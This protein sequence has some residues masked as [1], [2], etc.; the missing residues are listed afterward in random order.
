MCSKAIHES[1]IHHYYTLLHILLIDWNGYSKE[2]QYSY[3]QTNLLFLQDHSITPSC[4]QILLQFLL[5]L[6]I[7]FIEQQFTLSKELLSQS[8]LLI[9]QAITQDTSMQYQELR[10]IEYYFLLKLFKY[11]FSISISIIV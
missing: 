6:L 5:S 3:Y 4:Q 1:I 11:S 7:H 2:L 10:S 8:I 9:T